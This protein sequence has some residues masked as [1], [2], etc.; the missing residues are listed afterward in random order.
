MGRLHAR[1]LDLEDAV[2]AAYAI[3]FND[4]RDSGGYGP[5]WSI[6]S[7]LRSVKRDR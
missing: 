5:L 6:E 1:I 7:I 3:A 2:D 4:L